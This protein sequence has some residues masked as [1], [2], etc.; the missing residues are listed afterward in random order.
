MAVQRKAKG[1]TGP[2]T[3]SCLC[4][5]P[6]NPETISTSNADLQHSTRLQKRRMPSLKLPFPHSLPRPPLPLAA[7][8]PPHPSLCFEPFHLHLPTHTA[9]LSRRAHSRFS[10]ARRADPH[11]PSCQCRLARLLVRPARHARTATGWICKEYVAHVGFRLFPTD[12]LGTR[13]Q[14]RC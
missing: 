10:L 9:H 3:S 1:R 2:L 7:P 14:Q 13:S 11:G 12:P 8:S 6:L 5:R 4:E